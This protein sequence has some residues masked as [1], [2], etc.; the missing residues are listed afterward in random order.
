MIKIE[1]EKITFLVRSIKI[2]FTILPESASLDSV[3]YSPFIESKITALNLAN[4]GQLV[5]YCLIADP[6]Y[7]Y[8]ISTKQVSAGLKKILTS[9]PELLSYNGKKI[10]I[11]FLDMTTDN[12][13]LEKI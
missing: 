8:L 2:E 12:V 9:Y 11:G 3:L 4:V 13:K 10:Q 5:G 1:F 6:E 7:A